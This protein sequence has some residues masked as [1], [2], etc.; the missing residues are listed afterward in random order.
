LNADMIDKDF[1][2]QNLL[3]SKEKALS[4][5]MELVT[6]LLL[7][8]KYI[9]PYKGK[10]DWEKCKPEAHKIVLYLIKLHPDGTEEEFL[11]IGGT[12]EGMADARMEEQI[13]FV[14]HRKSGMLF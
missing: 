1:K 9:L 6:D 7:Q 8:G 10:V 11:L 3:E 12:E 14:I 2:E 5:F 4:Y 13:T